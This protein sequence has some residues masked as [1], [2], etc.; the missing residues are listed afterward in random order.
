VNLNNPKISGSKSLETLIGDIHKTDPAEFPV[1]GTIEVPDWRGVNNHL[2]GIAPLNGVVQITGQISA[3]ADQWWTAS[4]VEEG[5]P[6]TVTAVWGTKFYDH[7]GGIQRLGD[8]LPI[9]L[10][11]NDGLAT[12]AFYDVT[13]PRTTPTT[14]RYEVHVAGKAS[15]VAITNY[16]GSDRVEYAMLLVYQYD[17][18]KFLVYRA[19]VSEIGGTEDN[20]DYM[21]ETNAIPDEDDNDQY[22]CFALATQTSGSTDSTDSVFLVGFRENEAVGLYTVSTGST[23]YGHLAYVRV[24]N[25][26]KGSQWRYGVGLQ[27]CGPQHIRIFGCSEDPSGDRDDYRF[28]IYYWG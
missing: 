8:L 5:N 17:P 9:G 7:A 12:V 1:T 22:Q 6:A 26:W 25:G 23:D 13:N 11:N 28:P 4:F 3:S 15:A 18:K 20:W 16:T 19:R 21:G 10:E 2:Q 14:A 24:F 27:I